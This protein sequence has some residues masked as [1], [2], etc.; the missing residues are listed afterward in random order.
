MQ[1]QL[2][3]LILRNDSSPARDFSRRFKHVCPVVRVVGIGVQWPGCVGFRDASDLP[4]CSGRRRYHRYVFTGSGSHL[5]VVPAVWYPS[6]DC[7]SCVEYFGVVQVCQIKFLA[8]RL[9]LA[10]LL[11][12]KKLYFFWNVQKP[13]T[14]TPETVSDWRI[15]IFQKD[16]VKISQSSS[17][18]SIFLS[19]PQS[20]FHC[21]Y[22][23][24]L[25]SQN[26]NLGWC[27]LKSRYWLPALGTNRLLNEPTVLG[28][29]FEHQTILGRFL[30]LTSIPQ[31]GVPSKLFLNPSQQ[32]K[33]EM[34][35]ITENIRQYLD[36]LVGMIH[37]ILHNL[38]QVSE[39]LMFRGHIEITRDN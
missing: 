28:S 19:I 18:N 26:S 23:A 15:K 32:S 10:F 8:I 20:F 39:I 14:M 2:A 21:H 35:A 13:L 11:S 1:L 17:L 9:S 37:K 36:T 38:L 22:H 5:G 33:S 3:P 16:E 6:P 27:W 30:R 24:L 31:H 12:Q 4:T 7:V 34:G 29:A 25:F